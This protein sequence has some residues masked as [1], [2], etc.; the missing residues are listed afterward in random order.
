[1]CA[2]KRFFPFFTMF[3]GRLI[4]FF[5]NLIRLLCLQGENV[6]YCYATR[7]FET[8]EKQEVNHCGS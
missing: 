8:N 1:M 2:V 3:C 4:A 6:L 7:M 5:S